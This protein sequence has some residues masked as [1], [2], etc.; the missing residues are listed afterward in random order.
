MNYAELIV[1]WIVLGLLGYFVWGVAG[2][3]DPGLLAVIG[4]PISLL[5]AFAFLLGQAA[6]AQ[7]DLPP[8]DDQG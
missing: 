8:S 6:D 1:P 5:V 2:R 4:G 3:K 7:M